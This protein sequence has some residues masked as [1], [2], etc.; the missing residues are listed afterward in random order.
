ME[1]FPPVT[2]NKDVCSD[3]FHSTQQQMLQA[4]EKA[5]KEDIKRT[6]QESESVSRSVTPDSATLWTVARQVPLPMGSSR[7][8][9]WTG[10]PFPTPGDLL[11]PGIELGSPATQVAS[12]LSEPPDKPPGWKIEIKL[13][14]FAGDKTVE[15]PKES[16]R[17]HFLQIIKELNKVTKHR[18][19]I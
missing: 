14:P 12:L 16:P 15:N 11:D 7:Q 18:I 5:R 8:E 2:R 9:Y 17:Q 1:R 6:D 13:L 10:L 19:N 3:H 4:T